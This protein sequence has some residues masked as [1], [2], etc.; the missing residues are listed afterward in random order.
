LNLFDFGDL[1]ADE[2]SL[3]PL[4]LLFQHVQFH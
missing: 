1:A 2:I 4:T 3:V